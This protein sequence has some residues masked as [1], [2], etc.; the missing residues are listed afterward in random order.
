[1][2]IIATNIKK[3]DKMKETKKLRIYLD[4]MILILW[5]VVMYNLK[6]IEIVMKMI[7]FNMIALCSMDILGCVLEIKEIEAKG[8]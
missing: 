8:K 3:A 7:C 2:S 6:E 5:L 4:T 1:M